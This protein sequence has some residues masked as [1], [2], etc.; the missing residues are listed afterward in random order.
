VGGHQLVF[1]SQLHASNLVAGQPDAELANSDIAFGQPD[2]D[3]AMRCPGLRW[4]HLSSA[5]YTRYDRDD[6]KQNFRQRGA[7]LTNSSWV[8]ADPCAQH[9]LAMMMALARQLPQSLDTQRAERNWPAAERRIN[10]H[11]LTGQ[12]AVMLGFGAIARR[13]AELL[14]PFQM[15]L[16]AIRRSKHGDEP[17]RIV[18]ESDL[19]EVLGTADHVINLLPDNPATRGFFGAERLAQ[20]KPSAIFY[21]I[22]RGSSV[23]QAALGR[24]VES[25]QIAA[26]Y[27]DVTD[28]E[29]LPA[30]HPLWTTRNC[31]ITPHTAGGLANEFDRLVQHF[32]NN[33]KRFER[34]EEL[35]DRVV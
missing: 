33:L 2:P 6:F 5:G 32:L 26:A 8:Y 16:A 35:A 30:D 24:A 23:D 27:L 15:N 18:L 7:I 3:F 29:P 9:V 28:L 17:I 21:N 25:G 11:L 10:S 14:A 13:L 34:G 22:G 19:H 31:F 1:S 20:M 12:T 4:V